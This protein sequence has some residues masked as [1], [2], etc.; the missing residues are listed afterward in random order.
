M[1]GFSVL[2]VVVTVIVITLLV[3]LG[4]V[5][6]I[7]VRNYIKVPPNKVAIFTSKSGTK[8]V[9]GGAKF[10]MPG[11]ER[12]D[13]MPLEPLEVE[14][15]LNGTQSSDGVPVNVKATGMARVGS[16][17]EAMQT[18]VGR[19]LESSMEKL[20]K[21]VNDILAGSLRGIVATMTVEELRSSR[22]LL[23]RKVLEEA[24]GDLAKIG[25]EVDI[26]KIA[27]ISDNNGY[28]EALGQRRIAEVKRDATVGTAEA[29]RDATIKSAQA[30]Q[31]GAVAQAEAETAIAVANQERD[32]KLARLRAQTEAENAEADQAGPL[33]Q[34]RAKKDVGIANEQA[35]AARVEA[36]V[37]VQNRR[38]E[39]ETARL[40]A[41]VIAPAEAERQAAI[42]RAEGDRRA[43]ILGAEASAE[44]ARQAGEAQA[45]ARKAAASAYEAEQLA[46]ANGLRAKLEAEADGKKQM[47]EALNAYSSNAANLQNLPEILKAFVQA[48]EASA[49]PLGDIDSISIIGGAGDAQKSLQGILGISPMAIAG[50]VKAL[51]DSGIDLVELLT[52]QPAS[53]PVLAAV[54]SDGVEG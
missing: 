36:R 46:E 42:A 7:Y 21:R 29:E 52:K 24:G 50:T 47:A 53:E 45:T 38:A 13:I 3:L 40:Q 10:R 49:K 48:T 5:P 16:S 6:W 27:D 1:F 31:A 17:D 34:A 54:S 18:A 37:A 28:L 39:E 8:V 41:D 22:D 11:F 25:M 51:K 26:L 19:F 23:S 30:K 2:A 20:G 15:S 14:I 33:A 12:V 43:A 32:V 35:E 9:R 4:V 44:A